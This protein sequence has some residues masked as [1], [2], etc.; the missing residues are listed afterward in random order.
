MMKTKPITNGQLV[1]LLLQLGFARHDH[2]RDD[3]FEVFTEDQTDMIFPLPKCVPSTPAHPSNI[4][5]LRLQ[6]YYRG[7]MEKA[8][9]DAALAGGVKAKS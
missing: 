4:A 3:R 6:L 9:F 5:G 1:D 8:D 2:P 7:L